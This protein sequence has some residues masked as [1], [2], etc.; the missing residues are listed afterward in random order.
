[1][2]ETLI[3]AGCRLALESLDRGFFLNALDA[4]AEAAAVLRALPGYQQP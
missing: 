1:M 4:A 3:V 2:C